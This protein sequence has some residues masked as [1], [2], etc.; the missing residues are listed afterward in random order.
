[1][2]LAED[3]LNEHGSP[4]D[5]SDRWCTCLLNQCAMAFNTKPPSQLAIYQDLLQNNK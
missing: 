3:I 5:Y 2:K 1:M 4:M